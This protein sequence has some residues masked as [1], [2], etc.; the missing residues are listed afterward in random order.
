MRPE[1]HQP[2]AEGGTPSITVPTALCPE[3]QG[4]AVESKSLQ[5]AFAGCKGHLGWK[6]W[7]GSCRPLGMGM[8]MCAPRSCVRCEPKSQALVTQ[9]VVYAW[10]GGH[11]QITKFSA[12]GAKGREMTMQVGKGRVSCSAL[13]GSHTCLCEWCCGSGTPLA[14]QGPS[15]GQGFFL[16]SEHLQL[17]QIL[18]LIQVQGSQ[19]E[20]LSQEQGCRKNGMDKEGLL[21]GGHQCLRLGCLAEDM[22]APGCKSWELLTPTNIYVLEGNC[23]IILSKLFPLFCCSHLF[24]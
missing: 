14:P 18:N 12:A 23:M 24:L 21:G 17:Q 19:A 22:V 15:L 10:P 8:G 13:R 20:S 2:G 5:V 16:S 11:I 9:P 7:E 4:S 1:G 3:L 6:G